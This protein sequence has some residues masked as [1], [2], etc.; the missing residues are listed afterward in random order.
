VGTVASAGWRCQIT[1]SAA[2]LPAQLKLDFLGTAG[3]FMFNAEGRVGRDVEALARDLD[4]ER[5][6]SFQ[7]VGET[8]EPSYELGD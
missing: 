4:L 5:A 8:A 6:A 3:T 7:R 2:P 1:V